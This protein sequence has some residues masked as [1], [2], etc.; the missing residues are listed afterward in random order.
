MVAVEKAGI[1]AV[2]IVAQSFVRAWQSCVDG[3]GQPNTSFVVIPHATTGQQPDFIRRMVDDQVDAIARALTQVSP[4][5]G[6]SNGA[7]R[8]GQATEVF[9]VEMDDT[10]AGLDAVNRFLAERDWSDGMPVFPPTPAAVDQMLKATSRQPQ[11]VLMVMEPGFGLATVEKIAINAVMAGCRP[12]QFPVLLAAIDCLAQPQMNH[13]DMQVSGHTEAPLVLVNGPAAQKAGINCGTAAMGPGVV[14]SAN[15]AIGRALRLCLINIGYCKAGAGDPNFIGLPSK[16]GM[17]ISENEESS[18]WQ[19]YHVDQGYRRDESTVTVV[20]VTGPTTIIDSGSRSPEDTLNNIAS[21]M[22]YRHAG[23]GGW[24]RGWQS[25][26]VGHTNKRVPYQGPYHPVILSPSRAVILAEAGM[27]KRD[28]QEWLHHHCRISLQSVLS[29]RGVPK[30]AGGKWL[31][32]PEL[33]HLENDP[34]ATIPALE[35]PEQYLLFVTGG[36]T[37]Y[38]HFFYGTYGIATM[39]MEAM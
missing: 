23:A 31:H 2:A 13:R 39:P 9:T 20:T 6:R 21:M 5:V 14:N 7:S 17:C 36:S 10:I 29:G 28:A 34:E 22:F 11:D 19:P 37:H 18:P 12:E 27:S 15:T 26:Q 33:Q 16:F 38:A 35:S 1:P 8:T 32:H 3:W 4:P 24:L 25:A 30:D